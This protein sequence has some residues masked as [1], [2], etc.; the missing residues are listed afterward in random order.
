MMDACAALEL[1]LGSERLGLAY[2]QS[3][4]DNSPDPR[5]VAMAREFALEE[6]EHVRR[7]EEMLKA[8]SVGDNG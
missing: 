3:V 1:A 7:L 5:V 4:A 2:Y 8:R 6:Q